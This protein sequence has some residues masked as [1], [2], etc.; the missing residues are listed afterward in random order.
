MKQKISFEEAFSILEDKVKQLE[1]GN[2]TLD[3][4]LTAFEEAI[5]IVKVCNDRL[6]AAEG[7]IRI[8]IASPDGT[9]SDAPFDTTNE[10]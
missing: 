5:K 4:S 8:L 1:N 6:D 10:A 9:V 7:K 2:M 3:E